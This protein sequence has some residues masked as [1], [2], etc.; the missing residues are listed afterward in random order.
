MSAVP[1]PP[2]PDPNN[3]AQ[4][5]APPVSSEPT[6][7][8]KLW[9]LFTHLAGILAIC[10][11]TL[12]IWMVKKEESDFLDDQGKEALNFQL[13]VLI[14]SIVSAVTC[15]GPAI[16]LIGGVVFFVIGGIEANK[17][18]RYRYPYTFRMIK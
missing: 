17:G 7:D 14:V 6:S 15:I 3:A 1:P 9:G 18:V 13:S 8:E 5:G 2:S 16:V 10:I 12:I 11:P 4:T